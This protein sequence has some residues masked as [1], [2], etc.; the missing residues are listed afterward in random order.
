MPKNT[1]Y[2]LSMT[3]SA[4]DQDLRSRQDVWNAQWLKLKN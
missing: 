4:Q 3:I 1:F 2:V